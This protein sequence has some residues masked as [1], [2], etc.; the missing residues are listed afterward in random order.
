MT[1]KKIKRMENFAVFIGILLI[2]FYLFFG[3]MKMTD[4]GLQ[5]ANYFLP[6]FIMLMLLLVS[7]QKPFLGGGVLLATGILISAYYG[8][9]ADS[10]QSIFIT[11]LLSGG[12]FSLVGLLFLGVGLAQKNH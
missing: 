7:R 2:C 4:E 1:T 12:P 10:L 9:L 3:L 11:T 8:Y 5:R 6:A